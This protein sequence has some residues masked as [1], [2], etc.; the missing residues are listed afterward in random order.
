[1]KTIRS[2]NH[3]IGS[4]EINKISLSCYD[5]KRYIQDD[6]ISTYAYGH[7]AID[8]EYFIRYLFD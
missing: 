8:N 6:G 1:M 3:K 2:I 7:Y 5:D 4:Y